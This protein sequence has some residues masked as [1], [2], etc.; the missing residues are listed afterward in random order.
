MSTLETTGGRGL[1]CACADAHFPFLRRL[2]VLSGAWNR[3]DGVYE[4]AT[5]LAF[6]ADAQ[7]AAAPTHVD[8]SVALRCDGAGCDDAR[9]ALHLLDNVRTNPA[10]V[11]ASAGAP[12]TPDVNLRR[13]MR[14]AQGPFGAIRAAPLAPRVALTLR[15]PSVA[16]LQVCGRGAAPPSA[17]TALHALPTPPGEV[18]LVWSDIDQR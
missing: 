11:W 9:F 16:L 2:S 14:D 17:P 18:Q 15:A 10:R 8:L 13:R 12:S 7:L 4:A 6:G 1:E 3:P 5:L